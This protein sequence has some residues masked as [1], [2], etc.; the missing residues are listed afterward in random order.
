[1]PPLIATMLWGHGS[2]D[3]IEQ[4]A[5]M[6]SRGFEALGFHT[7][8]RLA[9]ERGLDLK[10]LTD[11]EWVRLRRAIAGLQ[12]IEVHA[13]IQ[14]ELSLVAVDESARRRALETLSRH[15]DFAAQLGASVVVVHPGRAD[16][17]STWEQRRTAL[18]QSLTGLHELSRRTGVP[19]ALEVAD[20]LIRAERFEVLTEVSCSRVGICLDVGHIS[21]VCNGRPG[22]ADYGSLAGFITHWGPRIIHVH[23]HDYDGARDH[24]GLGDGHLDLRTVVHELHRA[25]YEGM[26]TLELAPDAVPP[27]EVPAQRAL[28]AEWMRQEWGNEDREGLQAGR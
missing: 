24:L 18:C 7:N 1:M 12:G 10:Q 5:W 9:P 15:F 17:G 6:K 26:I 22:W 21:F 20:D 3:L 4:L 8:A 27:P 28:L 16:P 25:H 19:A 14:D 11:T 13:P 23:L 2:R